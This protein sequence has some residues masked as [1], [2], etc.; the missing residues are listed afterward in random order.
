MFALLVCLELIVLNRMLT[1][2]N[3]FFRRLC[4]PVPY[5]R[6][7]R[8]CSSLCL[9][10]NAYVLHNAVLNSLHDWRE[11]MSPFPLPLVHI[12]IS[13]SRPQTS[14]ADNTSCRHAYGFL[15]YCEVTYN[16]N[17]RSFE[18]FLFHCHSQSHSTYHIE[19]LSAGTRFATGL[20]RSLLPPQPV[21]L[22]LCGTNV[23]YRFPARASE[24]KSPR[25]RNS[26]V[27]VSLAP[28]VDV[29]C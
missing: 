24:S 1:S 28:W 12:V 25:A 13:F 16:H 10:F 7:H 19:S 29:I 2:C 8:R 5:Q 17:S 18:A 4:H 15:D 9:G 3:W 22:S 23:V 11:G 14:Y 27:D 6:S 26:E 21:S 20:L